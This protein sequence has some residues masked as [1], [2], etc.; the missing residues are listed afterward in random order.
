M[1]TLDRL[2][3][4]G[5]LKRVKRGRAFVYETRLSRPEFESARAADALRT[6][7]AGD[8]AALTPLMSFFVDAVSERDSEL[9][10]ELE[11]MV[12]ARRAEIEGKRS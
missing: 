8:D 7:I 3:R 9:L 4:K 5:V 12:H 6:A 1:T 10:D 2:F 11:A